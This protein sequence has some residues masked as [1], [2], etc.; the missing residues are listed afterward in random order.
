M[1]VARPDRDKHTFRGEVPRA[2]VRPEEHL[3]WPGPPTVHEVAWEAD[4]AALLERIQACPYEIRRRTLWGVYEAKVRGR[5]RAQI[6]RMAIQALSR[7]E[8]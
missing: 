6:K 8:G 2:N 4:I 5:S 7:E 1:G 3:D